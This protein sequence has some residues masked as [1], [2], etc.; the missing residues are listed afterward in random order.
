VLNQKLVTLTPEKRHYN[1]P[2][3]LIALSGGIA[4]GKS[5]VSKFLNEKNIRTIC[6]DQMIKT[7]YQKDQTFDFIK[8]TFPQVITNDQ[9]SFEALRSLAFNNPKHLEKLENFLY[10]QMEEIFSDNLVQF[11]EQGFVVYDVPLLYEKNLYQKVDFHICVY[12][13]RSLQ[14]ERLIKRDGTTT[15]LAEKILQ[16]QMDIEKKKSLSN[17]IVDNSGDLEHLQKS[18]QKLLDFLVM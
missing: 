7:I 2:L 3:P 1:C 12:S 15:Q 5:S 16:S 18:C 9:I 6:A 13:P 10:P 14:I 11:Q 4:T 8:T 17:Y